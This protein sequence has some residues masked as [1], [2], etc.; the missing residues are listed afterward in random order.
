MRREDPRRLSSSEPDEWPEGRRCG[1]PISW[2][3][4]SSSSTRDATRGWRSPSERPESESVPE[5]KRRE[6][7]R[8]GLFR[9][10]A[11]WPLSLRGRLG[12]IGEPRLEVLTEE[13]DTGGDGPILPRLRVAVR[14]GEESGEVGRKGGERV[15]GGVFRGEAE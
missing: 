11:E 3:E 13:E 8:E 10:A 7:E 14:G 1:R 2:S 6:D 5:W 12:E 4:T 15:S 9:G